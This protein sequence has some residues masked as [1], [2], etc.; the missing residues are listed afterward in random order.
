MGSVF[1][2]AALLILF[3]V[4]A[5]HPFT[6]E[7]FASGTCTNRHSPT[8]ENAFSIPAQGAPE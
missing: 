8:H 6:G 4:P 7:G 3:D 2:L 1:P 5:A